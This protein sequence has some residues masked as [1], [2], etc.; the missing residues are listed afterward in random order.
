MPQ[1]PAIDSD[2]WKL[3]DV[4][5]VNERRDEKKLK[6]FERN[7]LFRIVTFMVSTRINQEIKNMT[8]RRK[9][10]ELKKLYNNPDIY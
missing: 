3:L 1:L 9:N 10:E 2:V 7:V 5:F 8:E 6:S 4:D